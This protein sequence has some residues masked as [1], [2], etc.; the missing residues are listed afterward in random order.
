MGL[1]PC[2][3]GMK[4]GDSV[5]SGGRSCLG[6]GKGSEHPG[7]CPLYRGLLEA[8]DAEMQFKQWK[9]CAVAS[10]HSPLQIL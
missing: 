2:P 5:P 1:F 9:H 6:G 8:S 3:A 7:R 10:H 4:K